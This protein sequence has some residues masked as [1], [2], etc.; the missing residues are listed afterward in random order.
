MIDAEHITFPVAYGLDAMQA[1]RTLRC[2][3]QDD[4]DGAFLQPAA[5]IIRP[6]GSIESATYSTSAVGRMTAKEALA[7][8]GNKCTS[9][10]EPLP[11]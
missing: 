1:A 3:Y 9:R 7:V 6:D 2:F 4:P 11:R 8:R 5:F 10:Q